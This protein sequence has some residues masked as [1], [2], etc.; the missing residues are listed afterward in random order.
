MMFLQLWLLENLGCLIY[1]INKKT[2][3]FF[4]CRHQ[5]SC[6]LLW[7]KMMRKPEGKEEAE[8]RR[9]SSINS[10]ALVGWLWLHAA[11]VAKSQVVCC[12]LL[13]GLNH[14]IPHTTQNNS[15]YH[16][17]QQKMNIFLFVFIKFG[18][19]LFFH[20]LVVLLL[21]QVYDPLNMRHHWID[22]T[23]KHFPLI[24]D[25]ALTVQRQQRHA[26]PNVK[27]QFFFSFH[28]FTYTLLSTRLW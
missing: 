16:Q 14:P 13:I 4:F 5:A 3:F 24:S 1:D 11:I 6:E 27:F 25:S 19:F 7:E 18:T 28:N 22:K 23:F 26:N 20:F 9:S 12:R 15:Q 2:D 8:E 17:E 10:R 21:L